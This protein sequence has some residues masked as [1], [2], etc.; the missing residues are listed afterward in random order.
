MPALA[1]L[2]QLADDMNTPYGYGLTLSNAIN[3]RMHDWNRP[4]PVL[5]I[6][7]PNKPAPQKLLQHKSDY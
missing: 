6:L 2:R 3:I 1:E 4:P 7:L 5:P